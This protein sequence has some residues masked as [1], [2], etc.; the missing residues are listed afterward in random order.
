MADSPE[1]EIESFQL[2]SSEVNHSAWI[3]CCIFT[4]EVQCHRIKWKI[5]FGQQEIL[6]LP[7]VLWLQFI[8]Q[9]LYTKWNALR[10]SRHESIDRLPPLSWTMI[11]EKLAENRRQ[12]G[13]AFEAYIH[14]LLK[15]NWVLRE[16]GNEIRVAEC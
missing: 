12:D 2:I 8:G 13:P 4:G 1:D 7:F 3:P 10:C 5:H 16:F 9:W 15:N 6:R 14:K 11:A